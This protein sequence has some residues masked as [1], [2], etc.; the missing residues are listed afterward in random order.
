MFLSYCHFVATSPGYAP[1]RD[2]EFLSGQQVGATVGITSG[3]WLPSQYDGAPRAVIRVSQLWSDGVV[4]RSEEKRIEAEWIDFL[5][6]RPSRIKDLSIWSRVK[7]EIVDALAGQTQLEILDLKWG[8]YTDLTPIG[9]LSKLTELRLGGAKKVQ[10]LTPLAGL[11]SL[12][13]LE[14]DEA[15]AVNDLSPLSNLTGL[16]SLT[17]GSAYPGSDKTVHIRNLD[18]IEPLVNLQDLRLPGTSL[19]GLD[20]A[21]FTR[22]PKLVTLSIP[23][24][25]RHRAQIIALAEASEPFRELVT[26]YEFLDSLT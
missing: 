7:Q 18:W 19:A 22:L 16:T 12:R 13:K 9:H 8:S 23:L 11:T 20:L 1:T 3:I 6:Q 26:R 25:A 15:H 10:D 17:F 4:K 5:S 14:V 21:V 24:R 2:Q